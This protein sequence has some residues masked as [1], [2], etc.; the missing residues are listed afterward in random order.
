MI[1][2]QKVAMPWISY[3]A[4]VGICLV[5]LLFVCDACLP[6]AIQRVEPERKYDIRVR[7]TKAGPEAVTFSGHSVDYGVRHQVEIVEDLAAASRTHSAFASSESNPDASS[8]QRFDLPHTSKARGR[9]HAAHAASRAGSF[10][11]R[12]RRRTRNHDQLLESSS[13]VKPTFSLTW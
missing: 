1:A 6:K 9:H 11:S 8:K 2:K 10:A 12:A 13:S 3:F 7:S 4:S 5:G